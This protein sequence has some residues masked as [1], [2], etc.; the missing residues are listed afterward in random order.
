MVDDFQYYVSSGHV[1]KQSPNKSLAISTF[2][3]AQERYATYA[4]VFGRLNAKYILENAYEATREAADALL[5]LDGF[6]SLS[7]EASIAYLRTKGF[8]ES[9]IRDFDRF[10]AIRNGIKYY[11]KGCDEKDAQEALQLAEKIINRVKGMLQ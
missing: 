11:G 5:Y 3:E 4:S 6:K 9:D 1:K 8:S 7:H 10:R 2:K